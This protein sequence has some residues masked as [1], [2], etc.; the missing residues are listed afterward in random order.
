[1]S[2]FSKRSSVPGPT[3]LWDSFE[4][5]VELPGVRLFAPRASV[6]LEDTTLLIR[7]L[8]TD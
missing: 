3:T 7:L 6:Q 4:L 1:M 2:S 5:D 8:P